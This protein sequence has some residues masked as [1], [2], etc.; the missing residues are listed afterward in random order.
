MAEF[1]GVAFI[2]SDVERFCAELIGLAPA[3]RLRRLAELPDK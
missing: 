1:E 2:R 3:I